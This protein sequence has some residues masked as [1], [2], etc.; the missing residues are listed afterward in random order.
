MTERTFSI[1]KP[2][3]VKR[4]LIGAILTRF[5]QNGFKI[6]ASKMVRLTREQAEG[7]Y[8]EHQG[9]EFFAPLVDYMMSSPI[10]VSV[11]EKE[12]AV[13]DYRTLIGTTNPETAEEGTIRK[14]FAL[15]QRENSVHGSDSIE[16]ANREIAYFFTDCEIF[17]R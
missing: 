9:K 6:I 2:D 11:L 17:E 4:N 5:E 16:N 10:V 3:A 13:K 1:I 12:N 15:S 7:F 14:D 8:A